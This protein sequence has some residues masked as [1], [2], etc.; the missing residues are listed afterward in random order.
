VSLSATS[1]SFGSVAVG[2][3]SASQTVTLTN[4]G[5]MPVT[6]KS[7]GVTG[8]NA[9]SFVFASTCGSS[10]AA[11]ASCTVHGYFSPAAAGAMSA[12]VNIVD[13]ATNS[14]QVISLSGTGTATAELP[15]L[16]CSASTMKGAGTDACTVSLGAA[17]TGGSFTVNLASSSS[18]VVVPATVTVPANASSAAFTATVSAVSTAQT[19]TLTASAAGVSKTFALTLSPATAAGTLSA[20]ASTIAFGDVTVNSPATQQIVLTATGGAVAVSSVKISGSGFSFSGASFPLTLNS[21]QSTS[22]N[23]QFD[24]TAAGA[25]TGQL[26]ITSNSSSKSTMTIALTGTGATKGYVV[27]LSW[28]APASSS[29]PVA[30]YHIY[31]SASGT[32]SYQLLG[33]VG[34]AQLAFTDS[35]VTSG[36]SYNYMVESVD[37]SG[38]ESGPSNVLALSVP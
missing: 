16:T 26:T 9:S 24:P 21:G 20:N 18:A 3:T 8:A 23:I 33:S 12:A 14:P 6:I 13:N 37:A 5:R 32:S 28:S 15:A 22:L 35:G 2:A 36:Q 7:I 34:T 10:L 17:N 11:R 19:V 30:G 25:I 38:V 29:D 31:R 1:L 27:N 4:S